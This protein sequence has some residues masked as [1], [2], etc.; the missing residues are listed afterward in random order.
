[1]VKISPSLLSADFSN[2]SFEIDRI[3]SHAD[4]IHFDVMDG[5]FVPNLTFGPMIIQSVRKNTNLPFDVHLM[6]TN[7]DQYLKTFADSGADILTV[8]AETCQ[9]L[10]RTLHSIRSLG[11]KAGLALNPATPLAFAEN[12]L[13]VIDLLLIMTVDPGFGSQPFIQ[14]TLPKIKKAKE[15]I[16]TADH[17]IE[18][19]VDGGIHPETA[20]WVREAGATVL[21]AGSAVFSSSDEPRTAIKKLRGDKP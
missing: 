7:P 15:L 2:L 11:K 16:K 21:V 12:V 17:A 18:L 14:K 4:F 10:Y 5:H 8:H 1:M 20:A 6:I 13:D 19:E 9:T 3:K